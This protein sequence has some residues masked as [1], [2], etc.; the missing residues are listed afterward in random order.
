[1]LVAGSIRRLEPEVGDIEI[2]AIP[3]RGAL[4]AGKQ[5]VAVPDLLQVEL[6]EIGVAIKGLGQAVV[7]S[8]RG[9]QL[10]HAGVGGL[11]VHNGFLRVGSK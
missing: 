4:G 3:R 1:M 11:W 9:Q 2:V 10:R 6:V 8:A 5:P 7:R